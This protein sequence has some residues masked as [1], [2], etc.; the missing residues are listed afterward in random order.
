[1]KIH[2]IIAE[3]ER[4]GFEVLAMRKGISRN[5]IEVRGQAPKELPII[6]EKRAGVTRLIKS[7]KLFGQVILFIEGEANAN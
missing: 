1:M 4:R 2:P 5:V 7:A 3:L 6:T